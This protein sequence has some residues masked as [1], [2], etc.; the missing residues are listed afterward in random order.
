MEFAR[1]NRIGADMNLPAAGRLLSINNYFYRR[2]GAEVVFL[3]QNR[4][5]EEIGW[6]VVPFSMRHA[7]NL[8]SPWDDYFVDEIEFGNAYSL[9]EKVRMAHKIVFSMEARKKIN[10]LVDRV[11][12]QIAHAHNVY[13]HISPSIF[14]ALKSRGIP[15]VLTLHDLKIACPAYKM[16]THDGLCERCKGGKLWNVVSNKCVKG[17]TAVSAVVFAEAVVNRLMGSYTRHV[18]RFVVPSRFF[19]DK[20]VEWGYPRDRFFHIP[21]FVNAAALLPRGEVGR[22]FTYFGR[23]SADKG[24]ATFIRAVAQAGVQAHLIGTGPDEAALKS[25]ASSLGANVEF[26]G[27]RSGEAL[28]EAIRSSRATVV[29]SELYENS[30]MS[31]M[32]SYA[33]ERPVIGAAIGGIPELVRPGETGD[34]FESGNVDALAQVLARF[35]AKSTAEVA[36]MGRAARAWMLDEFTDIRYR[37]RILGLYGTLGLA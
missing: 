29:P 11:Q 23:L 7:N 22:A 27:Y 34:L 21:N 30:P 8:Q 32:E 2:G 28:F 13:H 37:E 16:L 1:T 17:S 14:G 12:P 6:E 36:T 4:L 18:D 15:T 31:I 35:S 3:E 26:P 33:L 19:I 25:L 9:P 5:F 24:L 10:A 20:F